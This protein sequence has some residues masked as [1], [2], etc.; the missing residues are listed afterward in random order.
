MPRPYNNGWSFPAIFSSPLP[1]M[2]FCTFCPLIGISSQSILIHSSHSRPSS[3][4]PRMRQGESEAAS[5]RGYCCLLYSATLER[6]IPPGFQKHPSQSNRQ[7][8][9]HEKAQQ[10][11]E[12]DGDRDRRHRC[13]LAPRCLCSNNFL[14]EEEKAEEKATTI[15]GIHGCCS[16]MAAQDTS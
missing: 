15:C 2:A 10:V 4:L 7:Q 12:R 16:N 13:C 6:H 8:H 14:S 5:E 9:V 3:N 1:E 11:T